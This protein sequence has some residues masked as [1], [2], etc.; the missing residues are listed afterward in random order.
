[1]AAMTVYRNAVADGSALWQ[2]LPCIVRWV[3]SGGNFNPRL[4]DGAGPVSLAGLWGAHTEE[5]EAKGTLVAKSL[6]H[7]GFQHPCRAWTLRRILVGA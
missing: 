3:W 1:M 5:V 6:P 2:D 7:E 4:C